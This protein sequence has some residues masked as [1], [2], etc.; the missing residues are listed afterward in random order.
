MQRSNV[1]VE[2][3]DPRKGAT[4]HVASEDDQAHVVFL[5]ASDDVLLNLGNDLLPCTL[6]VP[7]RLLDFLPDACDGV[8]LTLAVGGF[9]DSVGVHGQA[10]TGDEINFATF[11]RNI[12]HDAER[13]AADV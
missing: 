9:E 12:G 11:K 2:K 10:I 4:S 7:R 5:L 1:L 3:R 13:R 6:H 8:L